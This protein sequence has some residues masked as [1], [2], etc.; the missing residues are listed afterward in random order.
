MPLVLDLGTPSRTPMALH[1]AS[2]QSP[3]LVLVGLVLLSL[4]SGRLAG[5]G[6]EARF[7]APVMLP[8]VVVEAPAAAGTVWLPEAVVV[9]EAPMG[10]PVTLPEVVVTAER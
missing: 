2:L 9:A 6:A 7:G 5:A 10:T 4:V 1:S 8:E 3:S